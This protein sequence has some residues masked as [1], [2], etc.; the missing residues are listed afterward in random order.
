MASLAYCPVSLKQCQLGDW[1]HMFG[2]PGGT[3]PI[4]QLCS[5]AKEMGKSIGPGAP[6]SGP[7]VVRH[8]VKFVDPV[9]ISPNFMFLSN[10]ARKQM[11]HVTEPEEILFRQTRISHLTSV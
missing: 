3:L 6:D 9:G 11:I 10:L 2:L 4:Q 1:Y 8:L 5:R 7:D